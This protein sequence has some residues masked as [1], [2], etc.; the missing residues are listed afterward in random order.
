MLLLNQINFFDI[1]SIFP[2]ITFPNDFEFIL[3]AIVITTVGPIIHYSSKKFGELIARNAGLIGATAAV[4]NAGLNIYNTIQNNKDKKS[5]GGNS[6][7]SNENNDSSKDD[8]KNKTKK[9]NSKSESKDNTNSPEGE[10]D[11]DIT[12]L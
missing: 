11:P 1:I 8:D 10:G 7:S 12:D 2:S 6:G 5:S 3:L 4:G 9:D